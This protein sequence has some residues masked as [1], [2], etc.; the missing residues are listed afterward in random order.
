MR[1]SNELFSSFLEMLHLLKAFY[2]IPITMTPFKEDVHPNSL[3]TDRLISGFEHVTWRS[4]DISR[5]I[6]SEF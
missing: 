6:L 1:I 4:H 3:S 2:L 5:N